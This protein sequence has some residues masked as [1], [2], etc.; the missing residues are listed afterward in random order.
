MDNTLIG[1]SSAG[2]LT[3][4]DSITRVIS[5]V[6]TMDYGVE[7]FFNMFSKNEHRAFFATIPLYRLYIV[8]ELTSI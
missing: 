2:Q 3:L 5:I 4:N 1:D 7:L 8:L 6:L